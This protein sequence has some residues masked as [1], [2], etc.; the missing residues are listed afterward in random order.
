MDFALSPKSAELVDQ[1]AAFMTEQVY[2]AEAEYHRQME[3]A[4]DPH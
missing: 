3:D 2:P 1:L 4:R